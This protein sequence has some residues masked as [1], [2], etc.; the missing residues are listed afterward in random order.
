ME[1]GLGDLVTVAMIVRGWVFVVKGLLLV[2]RCSVLVVM[3]DGVVVGFVSEGMAISC[4]RVLADDDPVG[5]LVEAEVGAS[6]VEST[7]GKLSVFGV[8]TELLDGEG[9]M[10]RRTMFSLELMVLERTNDGSW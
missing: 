9:V 8:R 10:V 1:G 6:T 4:R 2:V 5:C 7:T 3:D